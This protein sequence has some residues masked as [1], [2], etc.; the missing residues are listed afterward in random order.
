ML[1][2]ACKRE[3]LQ[4]RK[5]WSCSWVFPGHQT[6]VSDIL[7]HCRLWKPKEQNELHHVLNQQVWVRIWKTWLPHAFSTS[8]ILYKLLANS[9]PI[10]TTT[11]Y[12]LETISIPPLYHHTPSNSFKRS[13]PL[14]DLTTDQLKFRRKRFHIL[15]TQFQETDEQDLLHYRKPK[16]TKVARSMW[17]TSL[18]ALTRPSEFCSWV[19]VKSL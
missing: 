2:L 5:V 7:H 15:T 6:I 13:I 14:P 4:F 17:C 12:I 3:T 16:M 18:T 9:S 19:S 8:A 10:I 1:K 11:H